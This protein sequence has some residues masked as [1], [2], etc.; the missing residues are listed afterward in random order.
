ME[1]NRSQANIVFRTF[2]LNIQTTIFGIALIIG[3]VLFRPDISDRA[4][5]I[6]G[7]GLKELHSEYDFIVIGGG[8]AGCVVANRLSENPNWTVRK[9]HYFITIFRK[10][11]QCNLIHRYFYWKLVAKSP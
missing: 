11:T 3:I 5:R 1:L 9:L 4:N 7:V 2:L 6:K 8:S 10:Q